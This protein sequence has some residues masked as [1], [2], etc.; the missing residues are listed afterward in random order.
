[1]SYL[2]TKNKFISVNGQQ[3]A[4]RELGQGLSNRPLVLLTHLA[5]TLDN[6]DP[7]LVDLLAEKRHIILL[8]LPGV[9]ASQGKVASTISGMAEQAVEI[10]TVLGY[11]SIDLLGLSMGGMIAQEIIRLKPRLVNRLILAGTGYRGG[12]EVDKV[13]SKTFKFMLKAMLEGA[14]PKRY[15]FYNNDADGKVEADRVLGRIAQRNKAYADDEMNV[16]G[17]LAQLRAIKRWGR[18]PED[19]LAFIKQ[20]TLV[21]NGDM[22]MQVPTENSY[23][24]HDRIKDSQ[25]VIYPNAGHGS[26]F[27]YAHEFANEVSRFLGEQA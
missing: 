17:F 16:L 24:M 2:I 23:I 1:M 5:A 22:D 12:V 14:D 18:A 13:T 19:D 8:D 9:G 6:W 27:Q 3:I 15:I 10:I 25:L 21:V 11:V 4:Y 26:I 7:V 20:P